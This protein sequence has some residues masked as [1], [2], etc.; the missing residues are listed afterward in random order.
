MRGHRIAAVVA[1]SFLSFPMLAE[2]YVYL[3]PHQC[4]AGAT[5]SSSSLPV[6][7]AIHREGCDDIS[8]FSRLRGAIYD[9]FDAWNKPCCSN[10]SASYSGKTDKTALDSPRVRDADI[11]LSWRKE[12]WPSQLGHPS[13]TVAVARPRI[14]GCDIVDGAILF[15]DA[16]HQFSTTSRSDH[17]DVGVVATHEIGHLL[18]LGHSSDPEATMAPRYH[19]GMDTLEE[20]DRAGVCSLYDSAACPCS[21]DSDCS[22]RRTCV[23]GYCEL[24]RCSD[25]SDCPDGTICSFS[26]GECITPSCTEDTDCP[27]GYE[28]NADE[29]CVPECTV[30]K[31]CDSRTDC[32]P[33]GI[34]AEIDGEDKCITQCDS[35]T[36]CPGDSKCFSVQSGTGNQYY[37]CLN[38][39]AD[40]GAVDDICP[41]SYTCTID[42]PAGGDVAAGD[43]DATESDV[44]V[45]A[46]SNACPSLG[47]ACPG[48]GSSSC[49]ADADGCMILADGREICTCSC[50]ED[51]DC[52]PGNNCVT[53]GAESWCYP[54]TTA[55]SDSC[56]DITCGEGLVCR[57]GSC[58][59]TDELDAGEDAGGSPVEVVSREGAGGCQTAPAS[60]PSGLLFAL[61]AVGLA[62]VRRS[63]RRADPTL[64]PRKLL[65]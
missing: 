26:S 49:G 62:W 44:G 1:V 53:V 19:S 59:R 47:E 43:T 30:C 17:R 4:P 36:S 12:D 22:S 54:G 37:L 14:D 61:F 56:E 2:G 18:G 31:T 45:D 52:G 23:D 35:S 5:W 6:S 34:C 38:P 28:C 13:K 27:E 55:E 25:R 41:D 60:P 16:Y 15:N 24:S 58:V 48:D 20:D 42:E 29:H 33:R 63:A 9:S 65:P 50:D 32:G 57:S 11:V 8:D 40:S 64:H 46:T 21:D 10:F 51:D 39:G 7:Y 3:A